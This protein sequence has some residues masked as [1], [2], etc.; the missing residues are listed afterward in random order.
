MT[1]IVKVITP[2]EVLQGSKTFILM[3]DHKIVHAGKVLLDN[4]WVFENN[5]SIN[6]YIDFCKCIGSL[7]FEFFP[8]FYADIY[9]EKI[10]EAGVIV[11]SYSPHTAAPTP[12]SLAWALHTC[13]NSLILPQHRGAYKID[14]MKNAWGG[15]LFIASCS[16]TLLPPHQLGLS[17]TY[18]LQNSFIL[19][20]H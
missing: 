18:M 11:A 1:I 20:Q 5:F 14:T 6:C 9:D 19:P 17:T 3:V 15:G 16:P 12:C 10:V 4:K 8:T 2:F 13:C 7:V